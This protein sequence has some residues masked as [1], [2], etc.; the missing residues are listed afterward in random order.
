MRVPAHFVRCGRR[1][2]FQLPR[3]ARI[4]LGATPVLLKTKSLL[5]SFRTVVLLGGKAGLATDGMPSGV[6]F[7]VYRITIY[8]GKRNFFAVGRERSC[9]KD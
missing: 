6:E 5:A 8:M 2:R 9:K 1:R 4:Q 7:R 3:F